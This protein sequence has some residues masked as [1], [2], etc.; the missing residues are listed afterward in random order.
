MWQS[1]ANCFKKRGEE[2]GEGD[3]I[4]VLAKNGGGENEREGSIHILMWDKK[5]GRDK[6]R[7]KLW[8]KLSGHN[9]WLT[10]IS[11][12]II[13]G[14]MIVSTSRDKFLVVWSLTRDENYGYTKKRLTGHGHF[15]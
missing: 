14:Y 9:D 1:D 4:R 12:P 5:E 3:Y 15:V 2:K 11:C 8:R 7:S 13:D 10:S 6:D